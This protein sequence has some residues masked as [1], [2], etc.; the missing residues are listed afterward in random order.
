M[1]KDS[2]KRSPVAT[3]IKNDARDALKTKARTFFSRKTTHVFDFEEEDR[4]KKVY[5]AAR[6]EN[7]K[8]EAGPW[9]EVVSLIIP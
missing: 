5:Y 9:S 3:R 2:A 6:Y 4:G 1:L 7:A 8:G